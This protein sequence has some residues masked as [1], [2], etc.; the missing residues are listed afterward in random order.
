MSTHKKILLMVLAVI[1]ILTLSCSSCSLFTHKVYF[2]VSNSG[3]GGYNNDGYQTTYYV[4]GIG[5]E[6]EPSSLPWKSPTY[7]AKSGTRVTLAAC[8]GCGD[9]VL[10]QIY[11]DGKVAFSQTTLYQCEELEGNLP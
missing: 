1:C 7:N 3:C 6:V 5:Y 2:S 4:N 10:E 11:E 8:D 9:D